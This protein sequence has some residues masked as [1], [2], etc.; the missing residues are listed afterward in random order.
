[1]PSSLTGVVIS[2]VTTLAVLSYVPG[3]TPDP[4]LT[5]NG[6]V[7]LPPGTIVQVPQ[8]GVAEPAVGLSVAVRVVPAPVVEIVPVL[9]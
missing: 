8:L 4:I 1:M 5:V 9:A 6:I 2:V 3:V 7:T